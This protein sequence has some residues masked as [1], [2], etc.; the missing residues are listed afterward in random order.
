[1]RPGLG[2]ALVPNG[3]GEECEGLMVTRSACRL[4]G[5]VCGWALLLALVLQA[6]DPNAKVVRSGQQEPETPKKETGAA[7]PESS[8]E[9]LPPVLPQRT[10]DD[11]QDSNDSS[12]TQAAETGGSP[13]D[14]T[15]S[16]ENHG[17]MT[18]TDNGQTTSPSGADNQSA[19]APYYDGAPLRTPF[20]PKAPPPPGT[21]GAKATGRCDTGDWGACFR[22]ARP[23]MATNPQQAIALYLKACLPGQPKGDGLACQAAALLAESM[24]N[25]ALAAQYFAAACR[26]VDYPVVSACGR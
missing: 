11:S 23:L 8:A 12:P 10:E 9:P 7:G 15:T 6:C 26:K 19:R 20:P 3:S 5:A 18:Q 2:V 16:T 24:G 25:K 1:M 4:K 13:S 14:L 17:G 22:E 21:S